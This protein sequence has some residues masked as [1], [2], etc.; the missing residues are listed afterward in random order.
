MNLP[1]TLKWQALKWM[2][3]VLRLSESDPQ[4]HKHQITKSLIEKFFAVEETKKFH[5][6]FLISLENFLKK[7]FRF[8]ANLKISR[9]NWCV[10][11][12]CKHRGGRVKLGTELNR[13]LFTLFIMTR[14]PSSIHQTVQGFYASIP[15]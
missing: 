5:P 8:M 2:F 1:F 11:F 4:R 14:T 9:L 6:M 13:I 10:L 3:Y 7:H 12:T 15:K